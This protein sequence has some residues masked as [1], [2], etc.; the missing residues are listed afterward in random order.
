MVQRLLVAYYVLDTYLRK[1]QLHTLDTFYEC[2]LV[3]EHEFEDMKIQKGIFLLK[4][5]KT[6]WT[7][8]LLFIRVTVH[9][10]LHSSLLNFT[11]VGKLKRLWHAEWFQ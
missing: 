7:S 11:T 6:R 8:E 10:P 3:D 5:L 1:P 9:E 2:V 4:M